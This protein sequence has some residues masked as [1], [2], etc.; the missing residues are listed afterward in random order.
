MP[1]SHPNYFQLPLHKSQSI[2]G[3]KMNRV[4]ADKKELH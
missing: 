1:T 2:Y 4:K 3:P